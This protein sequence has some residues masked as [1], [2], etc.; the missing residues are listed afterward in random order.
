[1]FV[2]T[3]LRR[4]LR[5]RKRQAAFTALGLAVAIGTVISV[6]AA[7]SGAATAQSKVLRSLYGVGTDISVTM[8][9]SKDSAPPG[10]QIQPS[11]AAQHLDFLDSPAMGLLD[12]TAVSSISGQTGVSAAVGALVLQDTQMDM[13]AQPKAGQKGAALTP[14]KQVAVSGVDTSRT[15]PGPLATATVSSGRG[16]TAADAT[17]DVALVRTD[18][19]NANGLT[20]GGT[21]TVAKHALTV[22]GL[23][24]V[25]RNSDPRDVYLPLARAQTL[26]DLSGKVNT[27]Y[28]TASGA[29]DVHTAAKVIKA[30]LPTATVTTADSLA[31][32]VT[33]SLADTAKLADD[34][35]RW[36]SIA[37][38]GAAFAMASL[39]TISS[40]SRRVREFGTLKAIGWP[41]RRVTGQILAESV[42]TGALGA[43]L[44]VGLGFAG[45]AVITWAAPALKASVAASPG[46]R[47]VQG[48]LMSGN[49]GAAPATKTFDAPDSVHSVAV[50]LAASVTG[51]SVA[52]AVALALSGG[53]VAGLFGSWRA[54]RMRPAEALAR[55]E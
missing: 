46:S 38:L 49:D 54:A 9:W 32:A 42:T 55:V 44:G 29:G 16:L 22:V 3:Y 12:A 26:G 41:T 8:P 45:A 4:E 20:L 5:H 51:A 43:V 25:P 1:M 6:G 18:Y 47:P 48:M 21:V 30:L 19:A 31:G 24:D 23:V 33:G 40:V 52:L 50:H 28:V 14:P 53:A 11:E 2:T 36:F 13:P 34:L 17:S 35:G 37:V 15:T 10:H 39:L 7:S 27:I